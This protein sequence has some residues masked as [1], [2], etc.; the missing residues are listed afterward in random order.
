MPVEQ[1]S[2]SMGDYLESIYHLARANGVARA[3]DIA[4]RMQVRRASV[5]GALRALSER[6]L[7]NYDPYSVV[8]LTSRGQRAARDLVRRH[9]MLTRFL[10]GVL[11][12]DLER[13][14]HNACH[15]E[16]AIEPQ[17]LE[18]L[19]SFVERLE[20]C[21]HAGTCWRGGGAAASGRARTPRA[22]S[23]RSS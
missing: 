12:V 22:K 4:E 21:P 19:V 11:G 1:L 17:V 18:K 20:R 9:E 6:E 3:K 13:A 8:T 5:T 23:E 10:H 16:H 15:I 2:E 14:G 7:V